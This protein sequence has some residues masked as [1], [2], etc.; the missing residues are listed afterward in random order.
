MRPGRLTYW[1]K[2]D[3][4]FLKS[5]VHYFAFVILPI[6]LNT[7]IPLIHRLGIACIM[8][9][10]E[11]ESTYQYYHK[12]TD[13]SWWSI[14]APLLFVFGIPPCVAVIRFIKTV[15]NVHNVPKHLIKLQFGRVFFFF[16]LLTTFLLLFCRAV[17]YA[18]VNDVLA[19]IPLCLGWVIA[20]PCLHA[21]ITGLNAFICR[22]HLNE[23]GDDHDRLLM[24]KATMFKGQ[25]LLEQLAFFLLTWLFVSIDIACFHSTL[26]TVFSPSS[27]QPFPFPSPSSSRPRCC[28]SRSPAW[29]RSFSPRPSSSPTSRRSLLASLLT[30]SGGST[31]SAPSARWTF[32][33]SAE[34][35]RLLRA[36]VSSS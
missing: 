19:M 11:I 35:W 21:R 18:P 36:C 23:P 27:P 15:V 9:Q 16:G 6:L 25:I 31:G 26:R 32:R 20:A 14:C 13:S 4:S 5:L 7:I 10:L 29:S 33:A 24:W 28:S 34:P 12:F 22:W 2:I 30:R 1:L 8:L 17:D 3:N